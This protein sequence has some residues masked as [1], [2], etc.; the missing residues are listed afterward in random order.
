MKTTAVIF[1][2]LTILAAT[3]AMS[4]KGGSVSSGNG[5]GSSMMDSPARM[6]G[7]SSSGSGSSPPAKQAKKEKKAK[8][9]KKGAK[10]NPIAAFM[11]TQAGAGA[12]VAGAAMITMFV[13]A[14]VV[15]RRRA[16]AS[17]GYS[18]LNTVGDTSNTGIP[19]P[20]ETTPIMSM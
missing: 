5:K 12:V 1:G 17:A 15:V 8:K 20:S 9:D 18:E 3:E 19:M 11:N 6:K 13:G 10:M 4:A 2:L 16:Q 14:A 7:S